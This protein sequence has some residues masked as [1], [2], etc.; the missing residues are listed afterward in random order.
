[1][2]EAGISARIA[3]LHPVAF[4]DLAGWTDDDHAAAFASFARAAAHLSAYPPKTRRIGVPG[5]RIAEIAG[6]ALALGAAGMAGARSFFEAAFVPFEVR[7]AAGSCFFTGYYEPEVEGSQ[8]RTTRFSTPLY[9]RPPDLVDVD[10]RNRP[11]GFNPD[12]R[13]ARATPAGLAEYFDRREIEAG[14]LA[15]R[16]LELVWLADPIDAFFIHIQGSARVSLPD[17][18]VM[19]VTFDGKSGQPYTPIGRVLIDRG[20]LAAADVTMA[21]I[22]SWLAAHPDEAPAVMAANR[23]FIFFREAA[24]DDPQ[25]GPVAAAGVPLTPGRSLA[26]DRTLHTFGSPVWVETSAPDGPFRRLMFAEDTGSAIVGAAR[27]DI[28][29]GSGEGAAA[30]A[31]AMKSKGRFVLFVPRGIPLPRECWA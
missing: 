7:P 1:V 26:V 14:A 17:G 12:L 5:Q 6:A 31:G 30:I 2:S 24:V 4:A 18:Q 25:L 8:V 27:G 21:T 15:G 20:A 28:F 11:P 19:R 16:D 3:E 23:S 29:F 10:D 9:C 13:F 22:R